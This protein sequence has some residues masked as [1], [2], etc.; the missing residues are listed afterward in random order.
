MQSC[1]KKALMSTRGTLMRPW[2]SRRPATWKSVCGRCPSVLTSVCLLVSAV[3]SLSSRSPKDGSFLLCGRLAPR[4]DGARHP[5]HEWHRAHMS[6]PPSQRGQVGRKVAGASRPLR[7]RQNKVRDVHP[8]WHLVHLTASTHTC[9]AA[10]RWAPRKMPNT[11]VFRW[12]P[13]VPLLGEAPPRQPT[14]HVPD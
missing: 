9:Q 3:R 12:S 8:R 4:C 13:E 6:R 2:S 7:N 10:A 1:P 14:K 11:Q 5:H